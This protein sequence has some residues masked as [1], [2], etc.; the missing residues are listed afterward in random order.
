M[1]NRIVFLVV[2]VSF[3]MTSKMFPVDNDFFRE[4]VPKSAI[5]AAQ[6]GTNHLIYKRFLN[7]KISFV[8]SNLFE[9]RE[10]VLRRLQGKNDALIEYFERNYKFDFLNKDFLEASVLLA[11]KSLLL[12]D[13]GNRVISD[14]F[15]VGRDRDKKTLVSDLMYFA[16]YVMGVDRNCLNISLFK[17]VERHIADVLIGLLVISILDVMPNLDIDQLHET[18]FLGHMPLKTQAGVALRVLFLK[19][20]DR[21]LTEKWAK[22]MAVYKDELGEILFEAGDKERSSR[23]VGVP[24][25]KLE[26]FVRKIHKIKA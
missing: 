21:L 4:D 15:G 5:A 25:D 2:L 23:K 24:K 1:R 22:D 20:M 8:A 6:I 10:D 26:K 12:E 3:T 11:G 18:K 13:I 16:N 19:F 14:G 17:D 7:K 9:N